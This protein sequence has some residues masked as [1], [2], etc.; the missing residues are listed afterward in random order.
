MNKRKT[1]KDTKNA[2]VGKV[3]GI[4]LGLK[5]LFGSTFDLKNHTGNKYLFWEERCIKE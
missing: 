3:M 4:D 5:L 2:V 1:L